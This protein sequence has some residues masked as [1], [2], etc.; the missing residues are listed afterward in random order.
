MKNRKSFNPLLRLVL[1][2]VTAVAVVAM[3]PPSSLRAQE[4]EDMDADDT[5]NLNA[6]PFDFSDAFYSAN[7]INLEELDSAAVQRFGFSSKGVPVRQKGPPAGPGQ[8]NWVV[9]NSN[10]NPNR[11][12]IRILATTGGYKDDT[13]SPTQFINIIAFLPDLNI[14]TPA[15]QTGGKGNA[16]GI[17]MQDIAGAFEAY[18]GLKQVGRDGV[19]RPTPC[20]SIG[21]PA[22]VA[23][24][25]CFSVASV[26]TPSLRQDWR[27]STNRNAIDGST[28]PLLQSYFGD[29]L[30]GL[31]IITYFWYTDAGFGPNQTAD[32][33]ATL[34]V[35]AARNG[36]NLDGTPVIKTGAE[37]HFIEGALQGNEG[38]DFPTP[39]THACGAEGNLDT[40]GKDKGPV[41]LVCPSIPDV[42]K[43]GI[44]PD[45]FVDTVRRRDGSPIDPDISRSFSCLQKTGQFCKL[46]SGTYM[47][48][49]Q[50]SG[51]F[52][53]GSSKAHAHPVQLASLTTGTGSVSQLWTFTARGDGTYRIINKASGLSLDVPGRGSTSPGTVLS[54]DN[55]DGDADENWLVTPV[56]NGFLIMNAGSQLAVDA[57]TDTPDPGTSIVQATPNGETRQIWVIH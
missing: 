12:N 15:N 51:L 9:D 22:Q 26:A 17:A 13:G 45:A 30:L 46:P 4:L 25:N 31:W 3:T 33:K 7:G 43:G 49:N 36:L 44:A 29:N 55:G 50:D 8:L 16:R 11:R 5:L 20:A 34:G 37:L 6:H 54:Q 57:T 27:F 18:V 1:L 40:T 52:W 23:K 28:G 10:S 47:V 32:C 39:P 24:G 56:N 48:K 14:F 21:D 42:T 35:L 53:D 2:I 41:W 19:F 38:R